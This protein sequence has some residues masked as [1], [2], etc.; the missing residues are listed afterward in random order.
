[1]NYWKHCPGKH[2]GFLNNFTV[3]NADILGKRGIE[4][5][6]QLISNFVTR[7]VHSRL[8]VQNNIFLTI[9]ITGT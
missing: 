6:K 4:M 1:M 9:S 2:K 5:Y 7:Y 3:N 8:Y